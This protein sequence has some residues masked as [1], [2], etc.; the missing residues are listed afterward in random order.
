V[1]DTRIDGQTTANPTGPVIFL[2]DSITAAGDWSSWFSGLDVHNFG[3]GGDTTSDVLQR[4]EPIIDLRPSVVIVMIGTN[5]IGMRATVEQVVRGVENILVTLHREV[6]D[7]RIIVQSVLPRERERGEIVH[8]TNIHLRQFA[9]TVK[10]EFID[11][12]PTFAEDDGEL[13]PEFSDD[14]LHLNDAGY[15]AWVEALRPVISA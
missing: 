3:V 6:P 4:L 14:R 10:A 13:K 7:L 11:L 5:D 2:G 1:T 12:W 8:Q 15:A 9:P